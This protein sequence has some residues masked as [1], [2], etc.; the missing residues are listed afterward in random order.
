MIAARDA[1]RVY[2][3]MLAGSRRSGLIEVRWRR[4]QGGMGQTFHAADRTAA[5]L[6]LVEGLGCSTDVYVGCAPR[7]HRHGGADAIEHVNVLWC[8]ADGEKAAAAVVAFAPP[9][10]M[11]VLSGSGP[12]LHAYWQLSA[13]LPAEHARRANRRLAGALGADPRSTDPARILRPPGTLNHKHVPPVPVVCDRLD[14]IAHQARDVVGRLP[15]P[16]DCPPRRPPPAAVPGDAADP[17]LEIAPAVYVE[18]LTGRTPNREGK[19][20]CPFHTDRTP[21]LHAYPTAERGWTCFG[22][23]RGGT[24]IDFG[25]ALFGV[26][27]RGAGYHEIRRRL[28]A[29]LLRSAA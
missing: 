11:V 17:L 9:P 5:L 28:A 14:P 1:L 29:E 4:P 18:A 22:C 6:E 25:A 2:L 3:A 8:D 20:Q 23:G 12:N 27:P 10:S 21:S 13:P 26:E 15:D 16:P 19:I 24:I 7:H